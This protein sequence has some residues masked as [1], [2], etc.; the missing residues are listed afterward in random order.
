MPGRQ[1]RRWIS[2][3]INHSTATSYTYNGIDAKSGAPVPPD[4]SNYTV[5]DRLFASGDGQPIGADQW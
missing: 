2:D 4:T 1:Q 3:S 5:W